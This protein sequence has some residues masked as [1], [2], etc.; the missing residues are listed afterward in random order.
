MILESPFSRWLN[1]WATTPCS[2]S[3]ESSLRHPSVTAMAERETSRPTAKALIAGSP[4]RT[5]TAGTGTPDAIA[6]SSTTLRS[7][8]S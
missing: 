3:R 4:G 2:S 1:S 8:R 5:Y 7:R 6:I